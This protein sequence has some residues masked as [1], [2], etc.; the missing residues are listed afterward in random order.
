M[1]CWREVRAARCWPA[2]FDA[3]GAVALPGGYIVL[4][5]GLMKKAGNGTTF[6]A[7]DSLWDSLVD[8]STEYGVA[9]P[10]V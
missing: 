1:N 7:S 3:D 10:R 2:T 5:T 4:F 6:P 8:I 9:L